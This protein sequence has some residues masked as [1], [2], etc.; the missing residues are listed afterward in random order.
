MFLNSSATVE[1]ELTVASRLG[2][3]P[4]VGFVDNGELVAFAVVDREPL[5]EGERYRLAYTATGNE[6]ETERVLQASVTSST[7]VQN[8]ALLGRSLVFDF[9]TPNVSTTPEPVLFLSPDIEQNPLRD[10]EAL[11]PSTQ[12]RV[13]FTSDEQVLPPVLE[14]DPPSGLVFQLVLDAGTSFVFELDLASSDFTSTDDGTYSLVTSLSD[15]AGNVSRVTLPSVELRVD[16]TAPARPD[17]ETPDSVVCFSQSA[18][19]SP[20]AQQANLRDSKRTR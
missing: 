5:N 20:R 18:H 3:P 11:G 6:Q 16:L 9:E 7:G 13:T 15:R 12:A 1:L 2:E 4:L 19:E 17:V 8:Q 14:T 10:V